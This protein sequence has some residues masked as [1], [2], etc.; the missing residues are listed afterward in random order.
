MG[1]AVLL[2]GTAFLLWLC[3]CRPWLR[4]TLPG[5]SIRPSSASPCSPHHACR[6]LHGESS[7]PQDRRRAELGSHPASRAWHSPRSCS[8]RAWPATRLW[9]PS[10]RVV[11]RSGRAQPPSSLTVSD[12]EECSPPALGSGAKACIP[13]LPSVLIILSCLSFGLSYGVSCF[14]Y[15]P[16]KVTGCSRAVSV[17][18]LSWPRN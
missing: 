10:S 13:Q 12:S 11:F 3:Q 14:I 1:T 18:C 16:W 4:A 2:L 9:T 6:G 17:G 7:L 5:S 8:C 15:S